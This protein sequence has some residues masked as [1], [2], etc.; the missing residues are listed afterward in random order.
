MGKYQVVY[1]DG[2]IQEDVLSPQNCIVVG[3]VDA[4]GWEKAKITAAKKAAAGHA[5]VCTGSRSMW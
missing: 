2:D 1:E 3:K 5:R 4:Q